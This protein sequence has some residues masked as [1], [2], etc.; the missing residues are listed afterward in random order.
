MT[1]LEEIFSIE[2]VDICMLHLQ[3]EFRTCIFSVSLVFDLSNREL[4]IEFLQQRLIALHFTKNK[5]K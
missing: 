3:T 2:F 5:I 1:N 4:N